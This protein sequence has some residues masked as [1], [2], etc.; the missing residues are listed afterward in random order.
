MGNTLIWLLGVLS[1]DSSS[2]NSSSVV[3]AVV[4]VA[5]STVVVSFVVDMLDITT[6]SSSLRIE[7]GLL[8]V[9]KGVGIDTGQVLIIETLHKLFATLVAAPN[10]QACSGPGLVGSCFLCMATRH[11][12]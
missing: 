8:V 1:V 3:L 2:E 6:V 9:G 10:R 11:T 4:A 7:K 12:G 5:S